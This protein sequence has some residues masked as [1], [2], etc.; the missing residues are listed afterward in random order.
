MEYISYI[1]IFITLI[2]FAASLW[3]NIFL[4]RR[5]LYINESLDN[6]LAFMGDYLTHLKEV[7]QMERFYGDE[8]FQGLLEHSQDVSEEIEDF[9][10]QYEQTKEEAPPQE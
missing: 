9:I 1:T 2:I 6:V 10:R 5:L 3:L 4:L 7:Y 8:I